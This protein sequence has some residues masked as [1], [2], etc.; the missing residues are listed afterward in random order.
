MFD[1]LLTSDLGQT[2]IALDRPSM[3]A[4]A[5]VLRHRETW[6]SE[7][8]W[9]FATCGNCAMGL[10]YALWHKLEHP[11]AAWF[12]GVA[13]LLR[14]PARDAFENFVESNR[15]SDLKRP[16]ITPEMIADEVDL[17]LVTHPELT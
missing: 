14:I 15:W 12:G 13:E 2:P 1:G 11:T 6:P 7:F 4:L 10:S 8:V 17:Y 3:R 9:D 16:K 5:Y